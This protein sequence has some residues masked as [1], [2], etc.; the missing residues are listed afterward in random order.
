MKPI[1]PAAVVLLALLLA[2]ATAGARHCGFWVVDWSAWRTTSSVEFALETM[3]QYY[4]PRAPGCSACPSRW[5]CQDELCCYA[6]ETGDGFE[7]AAFEHLGQIP[8]DLLLE[9]AGASR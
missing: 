2:P 4:V 8:N 9:G 1:C 6:P 3:H 7:P 5:A